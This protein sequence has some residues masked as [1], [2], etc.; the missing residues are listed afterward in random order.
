MTAPFLEQLLVPHSVDDWLDRRSALE[1]PERNAR[2]KAEV[3]DWLR[4]NHPRFGG[5]VK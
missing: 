3:E 2:I 5:S 4:K 1:A